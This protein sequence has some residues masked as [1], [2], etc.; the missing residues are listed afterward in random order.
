MRPIFSNIKFHLA[1]S[2]ERLNENRLRSIAIGVQAPLGMAIIMLGCIVLIPTIGTA[3]LY[4]PITFIAL[5][6]I[7]TLT[8]LALAYLDQR[9]ARSTHQNL[10]NL[11]ISLLR[12]KED[13][14][15]RLLET[16][17]EI[18]AVDFEATHLSFA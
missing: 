12:N 10:E 14:A 4:L 8:A 13:H 16:W 3:S 11:T 7:L 18:E 2:D 5:G 9:E 15:S 1:H 17:K 6:T